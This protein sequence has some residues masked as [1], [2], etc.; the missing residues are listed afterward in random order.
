[1][2]NAFRWQPLCRKQHS[3]RFSHS[4][5]SPIG[6]YA[7]KGGG[8]KCFR[9]GRERA[10]AFAFREEKREGKRILRIYIYILVW[11]TDSERPR[12]NS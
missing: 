5:L 2:R 12:E 10:K 4:H 1:M 7:N 9:Q 6:S 3:I 8:A 11:Q